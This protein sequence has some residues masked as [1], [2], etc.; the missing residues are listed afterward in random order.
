MVEFTTTEMRNHI[1]HTECLN[2]CVTNVSL[3]CWFNVVKLYTLRLGFLC[4][5][6][7]SASFSFS[8]AKGLFFF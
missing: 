2:K 3:I 6:Q 4:W 5:L 7:K 8:K 1:I